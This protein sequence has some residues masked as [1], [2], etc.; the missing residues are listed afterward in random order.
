MVL[1]EAQNTDS[2]IERLIAY[3]FLKEKKSIIS[4]MRP[5]MT[6]A[7]GSQSGK[8]NVRSIC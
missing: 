1:A 6:P 3:F 7:S 2:R 5:K 8:E 4:P